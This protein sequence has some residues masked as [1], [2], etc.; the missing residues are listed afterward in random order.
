MGTIAEQIIR[1]ARETQAT[2]LDLG[3]CSLTYLPDLSG[4]E[5]VTTLILSDVHTVWNEATGN[6]VRKESPNPCSTNELEALVRVEA[7]VNL[8]SL[9]ANNVGLCALH[10]LQDLKNLKTLD[11]NS[12]RLG[13]TYPYSIYPLKNINSLTFLDFSKNQVDDIL[14]LEKLTSLEWLFFS[15][16]QV[17]DISSLAK[18]HNLTLLD[19]ANNQVKDITALKALSNL[20]WL[21]FANNQVSDIQPLSELT[22]LVS[23]NF[24]NNSVGNISPLQKLISETGMLVKWENFGPQKNGAIYLKDNPLSIPPKEIVKQGNTAIL[25]YFK[26]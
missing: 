3:K 8:Q 25:D 10:G 23:L 13:S 6:W 19:F 14:E 21:D 24:T 22:N 12:N 7:L 16:N 5:C 1:N 11:V 4:L 15:Y 9:Y 17:K 2:T 20:K 18:L 26:G